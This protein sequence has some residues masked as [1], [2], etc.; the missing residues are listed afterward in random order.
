MLL[1][2]RGLKKASLGPA[3]GIVKYSNKDLQKATCNFTMLISQVA[4]GPVYK[5]QMVFGETVAVKVLATNSKQGEKEFQT[6]LV[7]SRRTMYRFILG[8]G[9]NLLKQLQF[10]RNGEGIRN[11]VFNVPATDVNISLWPRF[12]MV[13]GLH[14]NSL[15]N[16]NVR[17]LWE[18]DVHLHYVMR[19]YAEFTSSLIQLN[20]DHGDGQI[21]STRDEGR[22][23][24]VAVLLSADHRKWSE[25]PIWMAMNIV[26]MAARY[27]R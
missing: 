21:W 1:W 2:L 10:F 22:E 3:S 7:M 6:E 14:L 4:F 25:K 27:C 5:A 11:L 9:Q 16:A 20:V 8:K 18:D 19:R 23:A 15:R 24:V 12:K 13:F 26:V 17:T